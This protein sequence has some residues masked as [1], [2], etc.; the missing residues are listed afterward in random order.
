MRRIQVYTDHMGG[1]LINKNNRQK[2]RI[3]LSNAKASLAIE[4]ITLTPQ[5]E[6]LLLDRADGK[7]NN[8]DFLARALDLSKNV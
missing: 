6:Q 8:T 1:T 2:N 5:E 7:M 3:S 4:G